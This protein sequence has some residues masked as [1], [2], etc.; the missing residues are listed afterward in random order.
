MV[1]LQKRTLCELFRAGVAEF[2]R[3]IVFSFVGE[4]PYTY[5]QVEQQVHQ[6]VQSLRQRGIRPGD[7]IALLGDNSPS[8][9]IAYL[10]IVSMGAVV[11]PILTEFH[12]SE[13]HHIIRN[14]NARGLF[15]TSKLVHKVVELNIRDLVFVASL[16]N[17]ELPLDEKKWVRLSAL[18]AGEA[19]AR[20]QKKLKPLAD[21]GEEDLAEILY[22][23]GTMGHSKG[24][25]LTHANIVSNVQAGIQAI[26]IS[27][28][29]CFLAI[30]PLSHAYQCSMGF[31]APFLMGSPIYFIKGLP[32]AQTLLPA[33]KEVQPTIIL[34]VPL[35]MDKIYKKKVLGEINAK[36][37]SKTLYRIGPMQKVVNRIAGRRLVQ[38][39]GS[40]LRLMIF[41]GAA[42]PPDVEAF[43]HEGGFPYTTGYGLTECSPLL[44]VN[45]IGKVKLQ[46][47][48]KAIPG[49][50]LRILDPDPQSGIGEIIARG[51]NVMK[52]YFH[53]EEVTR[54]AFTAEGWFITGDLGLIDSDGYLFIKGRSKNI[55]VGP[56]GE[57]IY[58]EELEFHLSQNP[59]VLESLVYEQAGRITA[60]VYLDMDAMEEAYHLSRL[61]GSEAARIVT[62]K[63]ESIRQEVNS[64]VAAYARIH[65]IIEQ[66]EEFEKTA[67]KKIKRYLYIN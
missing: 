60:R 3:D 54:K 38:A 19:P 37:I 23:S 8:W 32:T 7:R 64:K 51:P 1:A 34:S 36:P 35:I 13:I 33:I 15:V 48:G 53:N 39:F 46:S 10:A 29:D 30:L 59:C 22:T 6:L 4:E 43:L 44:T 11:V 67:T 21:P 26:S 9:C 20:K 16:D 31:L 62:Q 49:V 55:I 18:L 40:R 2:S 56:S 45:P 66:A 58:P 5:R 42:T 28:S 57:N 47:A 50:T 27:H 63:L 61:D 25:M 17:Q 52:G 14:S 12:K 41:G 65:R 24:V